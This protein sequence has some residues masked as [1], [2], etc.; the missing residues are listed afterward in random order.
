MGTKPQEMTMK[1]FALA[2][3]ALAALSLAASFAA[4][5]Q[6]EEKVIIHRD[7]RDHHPHHYWHH[8]HHDKTV[9]I[10]EHEHHD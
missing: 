7:H 4:P 2:L 3:P 9:I 6:A 1:K 8:P 10:K 5:A